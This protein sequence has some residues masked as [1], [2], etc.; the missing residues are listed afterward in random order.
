MELVKKY[1]PIESYTMKCRLYPDKNAAQAINDAIHGIQTFYNCTLYEMLNNNL[2]LKEYKSKSKGKVVIA[3]IT[4]YAIYDKT[5]GQLID[6]ANGFYYIKKSRANRI[7]NH[8]GYKNAEVRKIVIEKAYD[9]SNQSDTIHYPDWKMIGSVDWKHKM[10]E[11]HPIIG[12]T[13]SSAITCKCGVITD[14]KKSFGKN[15]VEF[16]DVSYY[17]KK[18]PRSSYSYQETY[19][20]VIYAENRN[21]FYV[22]L[23]KI[24]KVKVRGWNKDI[25]FDENGDIDFLAYAKLN[26]KK[27]VTITISKDN[28]GD[29]WICFKLAN[30]YKLFAEN[31]S[32]T[33]GVDVGIKDIAIL[34]DGTKFKNK[35]FKKQQEAHIDKL[36]QQLSNRQGWANEEF[37]NQHR[38]NPD[39]KPSKSYIRTQKKLSNAERKVSRKRELWNNEI[40]KAIVEQNQNIALESLNIHGMWQNDNLSKSLADAAI[41]DIHA[42]IKYKADW[43]NRRLEQINPFMPSSKRCC[44]CGKIYNE[45]T[46]DIRDWTCLYCGTHHDRDINAAKNIKYY[47]FEQG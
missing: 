43:Y 26:S 37:R 22:E 12:K 25:R 15:P 29:Y 3:K 11:E 10:I 42:K 33:V 5:T 44:H 46:L 16:N 13:P 6:D 8:H 30:V 24:G 36:H 34:S 7:I 1:Y 35:Q 38:K 4:R 40:S 14:M 41:G 18:R 23:A 9:N 39:L 19:S 45:L 31:G 20:K 28:C 17:S 21:V 2:C 27:Q 32:S 47:A